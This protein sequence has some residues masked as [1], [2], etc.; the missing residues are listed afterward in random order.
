MHVV[1][2]EMQNDLKA[3]LQESAIENETTTKAVKEAE[4][5]EEFREQRRRKR[6]SSSDQDE[7]SKKTTMPTA[8]VRDPRIWSQ[9]EL[10]TRNFFPPLRATNM[11]FEG[12]QEDS[13]DES[14]ANSSRRKPAGEVG[15]LPSF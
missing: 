3:V 6:N 5:N 8:E 15:R 10:R 1:Y 9:F 2:A 14:R 12:D 11:E 7:K 13:D 4:A